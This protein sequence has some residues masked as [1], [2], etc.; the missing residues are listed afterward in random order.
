MAYWL[1][2]YAI[3]VMEENY[4][5]QPTEGEEAHNKIRANVYL[6][7]GIAGDEPETGKLLGMAKSTKDILDYLK[8]QGIEVGNWHPLDK[9]AWKRFIPQ[10]SDKIDELV[11]SF[12]KSL[13]GGK[14]VG[15]TNSVVFAL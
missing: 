11:K 9:G 6:F 12:G 2:Q 13:Y 7:F 3:L 5:S 15:T 4:I 14:G 10:S 8:G 1:G